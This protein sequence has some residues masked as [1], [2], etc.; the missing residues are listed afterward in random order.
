MRTHEMIRA[1]AGT[2]KTW[3]LTTRYLRLLM[4]GV[5]PERILALTF[6]RK[7]AGEFFEKIF[8][9]LAE[10]AARPEGAAKLSRALGTEATVT[11][12]R[13]KLRLLLRSLHQLQLSTYDSFFGRIVRSF[14]LELGLDG[15][16]Q[17]L[18]GYPKD[19][20]VEECARLLVQTDAP[21][22]D[23][24]PDF[25]HAYKQ[26]TF[27]RDEKSVNAKVLSTVNALH[28]LFLEAPGEGIWNGEPLWPDR[29]DWQPAAF[30]FGR[31]AADLQAML[32]GVKMTPN[33]TEKTAAFLTQL[34][35]WRPPQ[36]MDKPLANFIEG[37]FGVYRELAAG[38]ATIG[39]WGDKFGI[40]PAMGRRCQQVVR[41][42]FD[43]EIC[44]RRESTLGRY[45]LLKLFEEIYAREVRRKGWLTFADLTRLL[46]DRSLSPLQDRV[47]E[48]ERQLV[49]YRLDCRFDHWLLDEFQDTSYSQWRAV[50]GLVDEVLQSDPA[51]RSFFAVGDTK[52]CIYMWRQGDDRLFGQL[53]KR[54]ASAINTRLLGTSQRSCQPVLDLVN[55]T[56]GAQ[57]VMG[58]LFGNILAERWSKGWEVHRPDPRLADIQGHAAVLYA[59]TADDE[60]RFETTL[61]LLRA[62]EPTR[63]DLSAALL[64]RTNDE[65]VQLHE[66]LKAAG[67]PETALSSDINPGTDNPL[68]A[69]VVS[70]VTVAAHPGDTMARRHIGMTP[71]RVLMDEPELFATQTLRQF[72]TNGFEATIRGWIGALQQVGHGLDEFTRLRARQ[73]LA[74]ARE[75]D[76]TGERDLDRFLSHLRQYAVRSA[77][78]AKSVIPILTI[79]KAKGL[80]WDMVILPCLKRN[81]LLERNEEDT[82]VDVSRSDA[83][84]VEWVFDLPGRDRLSVDPRLEQ[85]EQDR[86]EDGAYEALCL[87]YV[88]MTRAKCGLYL[89][90]TPAG[91]STSLNYYKLLDEALGIGTPDSASI[92]GEKFQAGW[93]RGDPAW[94]E[95]ASV[96]EEPANEPALKPL[97]AAEHG[98]GKRFQRVRP[99]QTSAVVVRGSH[100]F[101]ADETRGHQLGSEVHE[102]FERIDWLSG[103]V[104][105]DSE[106][107]R[108]VGGDLS[109]DAI[110]EVLR[111]VAAP[112]MRLVFAK[113]AGAVLLWREKAFERFQNG[114][115][116]SGQIDRAVVH[117][118]GGGNPVSAEIVD[119]K[120][121]AVSSMAEIDRAAGH[122]S[123]QLTA[124]RSA[125]ASTLGLPVGSVT[126]QLFF[127]RLGVARAV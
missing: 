23:L 22:S 123:P 106:R 39:P 34:A 105:R 6:T 44:Q 28:G 69:L 113:P 45:R 17:F 112:A 58:R 95:T 52:Q 10:A 46:A 57:A 9:R 37:F 8:A 97:A 98:T 35:Q 101:K 73:I 48:M 24:L 18:D 25:W 49:D 90:T 127:T 86:R 19:A 20:A 81:T 109:A 43:R 119:F 125:L 88:A 59:E 63:R 56:F 47:T 29:Q 54:Y 75:F 96:K 114:R 5:P 79:H 1:S 121:D 93:Q 33:R 94:F 124:Y 77:E 50:Q 42:I 120:T 118:D 41:A 80:D 32:A 13:E 66:Y 26:A 91:K 53:A 55:E 78:G 11:Q 61:R 82:T 67:G 68:G 60:S 7:A 62:I 14:P 2:G 116:L 27:G 103:E 84:Q 74:A 99:S 72:A 15:A 64:V 31:A 76:E 3:Q 102:L 108:T 16:P 65:A 4:D 89:I 71:G 83:G 87:L 117:L 85:F 12:F 36:A 104:D 21:A 30:D 122:H 40:P 38:T 51:Q 110:Q 107:V 126:A 111:C 115:L 70:L 92:G 100:L